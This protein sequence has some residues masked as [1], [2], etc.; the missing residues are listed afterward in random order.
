MSSDLSEKG[1]M[2]IVTAPS[3][4]GK[5]T[6]VQHLLNTY[7]FLDFSVSVTTR[8]IRP[9]ETDG[10]DYFFRTIEEFQS[11]LKNDQ[12]AE[13]EEVYE[14]GFYG[15]LHKEIKRIW[16]AGNHIVFDIDVKGAVNLQAKF[17]DNSLTVFIKPPSLEI[18][19]DRLKNRKTESPQS[20]ERRIKKA[21]LELSYETLFDQVLI[22][23]ELDVAL[24]NAENIVQ[25]YIFDEEE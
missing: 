20:L 3:G 18:L 22:N 25:S 7:D 5:T 6:I 16:S 10:I 24:K 2:I 19:I 4:A 12:L 13:W 9:N 15:T 1:K 8:S 21:K 11:L 17:P 23:D 14:N